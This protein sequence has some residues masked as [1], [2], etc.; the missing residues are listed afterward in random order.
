MRIH[1]ETPS[2]ITEIRNGMRQPQALKASSPRLVRV[3][4]TTSSAANKS[5]RRRGL[6]EAREQPAFAR[7]RMFGDIGRRT[8]VLAAQC[9]T[10]QQAQRHQQNRCDHAGRG[11]ARQQPHRKCGSRP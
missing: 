10:L 8:A 6:D 11:V 4:M 9:Q 1:S 5:E 3:T 7:G 2:R